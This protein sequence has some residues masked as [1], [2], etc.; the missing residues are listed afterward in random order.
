MPY[1]YFN[2]VF[3]KIYST[4]HALIAIIEKDGKVLDKNGTFGAHLLFFQK[5]AFRLL[6]I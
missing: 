4:Q 2:A 3:A 5:I 6:D 1:Q